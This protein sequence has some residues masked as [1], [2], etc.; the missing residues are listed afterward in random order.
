MKKHTGIALLLLAIFILSL[1]VAIADDGK[2][3]VTTSGLNVRSGPGTTHS[4]ITQLPK[5]TVVPVVKIE[6]GWAQIRLTQGSLGWVSTQYLQVTSQP[7]SGA[8]AGSASGTTSSAG[9]GSP[10]V[11]VSAPATG[12]L[13]TGVIN[14]TAVN[15]RKDPTTESQALG[16]L[17]RGELVQLLEKRGDWY[18][19]KTGKIEG[20]VAGFLITVQGGTA[21]PRIYYVNQNL[22]NLRSAPNLNAQVLAQLTRN[23]PLTVSNQNGDWYQVKTQAGQEGWIAGWLISQADGS[24]VYASVATPWSYRRFSHSIMPIKTR[25]RPRQ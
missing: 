20:W 10:G 7:G 11:N 18:R 25:S 2:A 6:K 5:G 1:G 24:S 12:T 21:D 14:S 22:V 8:G 9:A 19:V 4:R 16:Q 15:V 13:G 17:A 23:T 3:T